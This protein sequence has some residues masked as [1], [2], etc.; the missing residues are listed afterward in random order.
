MAAVYRFLSTYEGLIYLVLAI[1]GMIMLR[2][3]WRAWKEWRGAIFGLERE[4][5][6]RRLARALAALLLI[7]ALM[8]GE[9]VIASFVVPSLPPSVFLSTPTLDVLVTPTGTISAEMATALAATPNVQAADTAVGCVPEELTVDSPQPGQTVSGIVE[10]VGTVDIPKFGFYKF[11]I[12]PQGGDVWST[13]YAGRD[14]IRDD[15]L[16]RLD[17]GELVPGDYLLRL[18]VTDNQGQALPPCV[19]PIRVI[20]Q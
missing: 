6:Q 20:G 8:F 9:F 18:V 13:V 16:G 10:L 7:L 19:I 11:E 14:V 12:S 5:A 3:L 15:V 1:G 17:T 4:V 2:W